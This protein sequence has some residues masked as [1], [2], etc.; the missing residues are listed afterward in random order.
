[1]RIKEFRSWLKE[2]DIDFA[3]L[4]N[5]SFNKLDPNLFYL[6]QLE[7]ESACLAIPR[8]KPPFLIVSSFEN[9]RVK[10]Y[11]RIKK[12]INRKKGKLF[13][14][15]K[16]S[17]KAKKIRKI[18]INKGILAVSE[19]A[20]LKKYFKRCRFIDVSKKMVELRQ[21]KTDEEIKLMKRS[22][23]IAS[24]IVEKGI[25]LIK[26]LKTEM[27]VKT[28]LELE[29]KKEGCSL[30]FPPIV[31]SG[32]NAALP[33]YAPQ[34]IKLKKGFCVIDFGVKYQGYCS[35]MTRTVYLGRP[36]KKEVDLYN[37]LLNT[38]QGAISGIGI[39]KKCSDLHKKV[40][41]GLKTFKKYFT[42]GL[43]H[44]LGIEIHENPN[45]MLNSKDKIK[46]N[47]V[48]TIEPGIYIKNRLG[49]RIED[50]IL[51][52]KGRIEVLSKIDKS[53]RII[54]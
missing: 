35:D 50:E 32:S 2:E 36:S 4:L 45:L 31:A 53:L 17:I 10:K 29:A 11:S 28:F 26:R 44:G 23:S 38:Q 41:K 8:S 3:L 43:G 5:S 13:E 25:K 16:S 52:S 7:L 14:Q 34:N 20:S 54:S 9:E 30:S 37:L 46:P 48:F 42:H 19:Y 21:I 39:N 6:T 51:F 49:I 24:R 40:N 27:A 22:A 12:V 1:M 18:G 47:M 33:H 15:L